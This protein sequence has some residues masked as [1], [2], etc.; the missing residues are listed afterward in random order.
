MYDGDTLIRDFIP[1]LDENDV[2]Y[3]YDKV[4]KKCYYNAGT[5][6]FSYGE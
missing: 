4:E 6:T 1:I 3:L 2:A 5:G